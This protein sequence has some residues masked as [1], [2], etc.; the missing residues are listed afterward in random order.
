MTAV[1]TSHA[2]T[3]AA[4]LFGIGWIGLLA[5][6]DLIFMLVALEI[7]VNAAGLAFVAAGAKWAEP[8]GQVMF[9]FVLTMAAS[10]VAVGLALVL[11]LRKHYHSVDADRA[12]RLGTSEARRLGP[13]QPPGEAE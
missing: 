1:P 3:L 6:R 7:M 11:E 4:I 5:R 8:D 13:A 9:L 12:T 2:L 10:E